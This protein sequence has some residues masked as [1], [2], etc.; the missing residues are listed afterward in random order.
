MGV[1]LFCLIFFIYFF[2]CG[3]ILHD[4]YSGHANHILGE[5]H[6]VKFAL[7]LSKIMN[8]QFIQKSMFKYFKCHDTCANKNIIIICQT[9]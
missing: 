8:L 7:K 6:L 5:P 2:I 1:L 4:E 3:V 9:F